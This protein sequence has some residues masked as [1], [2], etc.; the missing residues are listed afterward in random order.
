[1]ARSLKDHDAIIHLAGANLFGKR[2]TDSVQKND[3]ESRELAPGIL[4]RH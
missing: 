4:W 2:W 3:S 1:M